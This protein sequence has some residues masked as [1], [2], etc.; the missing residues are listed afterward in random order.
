MLSRIS[1]AIRAKMNDILDNAENPYET[2]GYAF[3][4]VVESLRDTHALIAD[5]T[6]TKQR[7]HSRHPQ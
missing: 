6:E 4:K 7:L 1:E 3:E 5:V 2:F